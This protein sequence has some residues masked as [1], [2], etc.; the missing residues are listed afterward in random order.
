MPRIFT[1][2]RFDD[3]FK[4]GL[5][6]LQDALRKRGVCGDFCP[7][8]NLHMTLSFNCE[9]LHLLPEIRQAVSEVEFEPFMVTLDHLGTFAPKNCVIWAGIK[10]R[11]AVTAIA[12][13]LRERLDAYGVPY[14]TLPF[15]PHISLVKRPSTIVTDIH[16]PPATAR[17]EQIHV[18]RS[19]R[20][21]GELVYSET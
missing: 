14:S 1:A 13:R 10:E 3:G 7:Y 16:I 15:Y 20:I 9:N 17:V 2:I 5:V 19:E 8:G 11:E 12:S 6:A 18:M 4:S 21:G